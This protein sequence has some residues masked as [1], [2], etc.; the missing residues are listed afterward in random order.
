MALQTPSLPAPGQTQPCEVMSWRSI[1]QSKRG[2]LQNAGICNGDV[3]KLSSAPPLLPSKTEN[4][5]E[6]SHF[7]EMLMAK[8]HYKS[9]KEASC[10]DL[11]HLD[12]AETTLLEWVMFAL[13]WLCTG[14]FL[15]YVLL[16]AVYNEIY[17]EI[18]VGHK[19]S[20]CSTVSLLPLHSTSGFLPAGQCS[21]RASHPNT[22][23]SS[24]L[25][26]RSFLPSSLCCAFFPRG[27]PGSLVS[28]VQKPQEIPG[29]RN[30]SRRNPIPSPH[31]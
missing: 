18:Q 22:N 17:L 19:G 4:S 21:S 12:K 1:N 31:S 5:S 26:G 28:V 16:L 24:D 6:I 15:S 11:V 7:M 9:E 13:I 2:L 10:S 29:S 27:Y 20:L 30:G 23:M 14:N 25:S 8:C 3:W